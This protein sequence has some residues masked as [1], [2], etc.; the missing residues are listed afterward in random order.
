M[1]AAEDEVV[2]GG[3]EVDFGG[4]LACEELFP[5]ELR[6]VRGERKTEGTSACG[7][8]GLR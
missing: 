5:V 1:I 2:E 8:W 4:Q 6:D 3:K 7:Q